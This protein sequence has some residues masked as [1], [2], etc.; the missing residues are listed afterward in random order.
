LPKVIIEASK[1]DNG[2]TNGTILGI[3]NSRN[4]RTIPKSRSLPANSAINNQT[5]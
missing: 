5:D 2:N 3:A 4:F 1:T